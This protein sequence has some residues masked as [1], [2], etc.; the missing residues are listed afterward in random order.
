MR[1]IARLRDAL[2]EINGALTDKPPE[3][4]PSGDDQALSDSARPLWSGEGQ[5]DFTGLAEVRSKRDEESSTEGAFEPI[6]QLAPWIE[7]G[8]PKLGSNQEARVKQDVLLRGI[9][10]IG[11]YSSFHVAGWQWGAYVKVS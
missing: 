1:R 5:D 9:D 8:I 7:D 4:G 10:A 3:D 6:F 2:A 11:W